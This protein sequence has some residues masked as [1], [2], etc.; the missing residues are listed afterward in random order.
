MLKNLIYYIL[1]III[2]YQT[3]N[4]VLMQHHFFNV[5]NGMF[6]IKNSLNGGCHG[7]CKEKNNY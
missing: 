6:G 7:S 5:G 1:H 2:V 4:A 3:K